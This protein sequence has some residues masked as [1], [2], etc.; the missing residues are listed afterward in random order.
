MI[1]THFD[2]QDMLRRQVLLPAV[3]K[4]IVSLVPSQTELLFDLGLEEEVIGITKF[5]VHPT[6]WFRNKKRIGG[7]KTVKIDTVL[8]LKPDLIIA[9]KEE[10]V[11][12]QIEELAAHVPVWVS[13]INDVDSALLMIATVAQLTDRVAQGETILSSIRAGLQRLSHTKG[14]GHNV[15]YYIWRDPWMCAGTDTF[16]S[17]IL[18]HM[19]WQNVVQTTRYPIVAPHTLAET[20]TSLVLLSSEPYPFREKHIN[21]I[22][23]VLPN[24]HIM[25]V[26]GEMFSWYGSRLV[27]AMDY[28]LQLRHNADSHLK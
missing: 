2:G 10:N 4:R 16:I 9:N 27:H 15:A 13:D 18:Q 7:T 21:E 11:R 19:G 28:L 23:M 24:A 1:K 20:N 26:D 17:N 6:P 12:E 14:I 22:K 25:L 8:S 3:P 5:C